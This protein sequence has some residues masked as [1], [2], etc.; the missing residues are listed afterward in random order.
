MI[1]KKIL[2]VSL[3]IFSLSMIFSLVYL[4][5]SPK[6]S[7][8]EQWKIAVLLSKSARP[9]SQ[10][11]SAFG[12]TLAGHGISAE[13]STYDI[14]G[15]LEEGHS[16]L[17]RIR[18]LNPRII[19]AVGSAAT[20]VAFNEAKD[21][22]VVFTMVLY[23]EDSGFVSKRS[24]N[25]MT[26]VLI[27]VPPE[28]QFKILKAFIP[29]V[30][31]I[32]VLY[33]PQ[34]TG[35]VIEDARAAARALALE[36]IAVKVRSASE[37]PGALASLKGGIDALWSVAD[38]TVLTSKSTRYIIT[39]SLRN[40]IPFMG[41]SPYFVR[42]GALLSLSPDY[43]DIG[44]QTGEIAIQVLRGIP[45]SNIKAVGPRKFITTINLRTAW[46]MGLNVPEDVLASAQEVIK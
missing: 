8:G 42:E 24:K 20:E 33:D 5:I 21:Y 39:Y 46:K 16:A 4:S 23:P 37:V 29:R 34:E 32:G 2:G 22:A 3:F 6:T 27:D 9:Y 31:R 44:R 26:G 7:F 40:K 36:L 13:I 30:R 19:L 43:L 11:L 41:V 1:A 25:E 35:A 38:S 45:A 18:E 10:A 12:E 28:E 17:K 15:S 14:D